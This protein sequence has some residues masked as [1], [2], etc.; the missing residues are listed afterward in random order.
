MPNRHNL[1]WTGRFP[2][3][4]ACLLRAIDVPRENNVNDEATRNHPENAATRC[5]K[6]QRSV[7]LRVYFVVLYWERQWRAWEQAAMPKPPC[8][9]IS[10]RSAILV[11]VS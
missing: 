2:S 11:A 9:F 7:L 10:S 8:M 6:V 1:P 5:G 3:R 4:Q